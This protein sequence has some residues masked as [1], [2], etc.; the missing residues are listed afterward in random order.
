MVKQ[1]WMEQRIIFIE[2]ERNL[3]NWTKQ[4][5]STFQYLLNLYHTGRFIHL[6][7]KQIMQQMNST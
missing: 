6:S 2:K 3:N 4:K 7:K 1:D 5:E